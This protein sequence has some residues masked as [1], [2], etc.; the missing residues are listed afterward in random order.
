MEDEI[1]G[2]KFHTLQWVLVEKSKWKKKE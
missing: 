2:A 1:E